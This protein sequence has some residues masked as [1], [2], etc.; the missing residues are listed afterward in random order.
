M[1]VGNEEKILIK[2]FFPNNK[3]LQEKGYYKF[4]PFF[5]KITVFSGGLNA[6]TCKAIEPLSLYVK[7]FKLPATVWGERGVTRA[8]R[9][10]IF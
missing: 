3:K 5:T 10:L 2:H 7:K 8:G 9:A 4:I 6:T 1:H